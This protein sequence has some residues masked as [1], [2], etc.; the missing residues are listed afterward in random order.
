[1]ISLD[2]PGLRL[3]L[4]G[5][6]VFL[7]GALSLIFLPDPV[8]VVAMLAGGLGVWIGFIWTLLGYYVRGGT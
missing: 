2:S 3:A 6:A 1:M 4:V 5:A 7:A 8:G